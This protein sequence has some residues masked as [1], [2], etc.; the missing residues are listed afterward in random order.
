MKLLRDI[1]LT[2]FPNPV[3]TILWFVKIYFVDFVLTD[4][5]IRQQSATR[6][7]ATP[8]Q[9][10]VGLEEKG[11]PLLSPPRKPKTTGKTPPNTPII[12]RMKDALISPFCV[13]HSMFSPGSK[14]N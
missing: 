14:Y 8:I 5:I 9:P 3:T 11:T 10:R 13:T 6:I 2:T 12:A 1:S 4:K 7:K